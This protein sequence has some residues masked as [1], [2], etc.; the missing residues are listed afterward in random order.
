MPG[1]LVFA[2]LT[3]LLLLWL[4]PH[5]AEAASSSELEFAQQRPPVVGQSRWQ[6]SDP[7]RLGR[8]NAYLDLGLVGTVAAGGSTASDIEGGTQLGGHDPNQRGFTLQG[9][10]LNLS[11][12]VDPY[13]RGNMNLS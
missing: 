12:A 10:E 11:G 3:W 8:G 13:F 1:N 5:P 2:G 7:I 9:I 6:P 4:P